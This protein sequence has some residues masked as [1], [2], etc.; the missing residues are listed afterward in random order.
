MTAYPIG[1]QDGGSSL[2][3]LLALVGAWHFWRS[4]RR[5]LLVLCAAPFALSFV[6]ALL[7][8]YPYGGSCRLTQYLAPA[9]GLTAGAGAAALIERLR[10]AA[11][12]RRWVIGTCAAFL[13]VGLVGMGKDVVKPY[14]DVETRWMCDVM[15][16]LRAEAGPDVPVVVMN[17]VE[18]FDALLHWH[19]GLMGERVSWGG[20]VDWDKAA[21]RG[22]FY[23]L[24]LR[25]EMLRSPD[26]LP[27][28]PGQVPA[29]V[30]PPLAAWLQQSGR[31]WALKKAITD[32][33]VPPTWQDPVKHLDQ[34]RWVL[35]TGHAEARP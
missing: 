16:S 32:V 11:T 5:P 17:P 31:P 3:T 15:R 7:H 6:A 10:S 33:G 22:E 13:L 35:E 21:S 24:L 25:H 34:Y 1:S 18:N 19:L 12:R 23:C 9:V 26:Q 29:E 28:A 20:Q 2:T 27:R 30:Y 4:G 14:R 8:R